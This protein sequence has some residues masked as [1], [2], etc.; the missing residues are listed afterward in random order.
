MRNDQVNMT[1]RQRIQ[2]KYS[3]S[4]AN[5]LLVIILTVV[6]IVLFLAGSDSM[7]LFSAS[8]PYFAVVF[9]W[10][11]DILPMGIIVA[12]IALVLYLVSWIFSKK[13][14]GWMTVALVLFILD[15]LGMLGM[16]LLMEDVSGILD[17]LI[18]AYVLY[19]LIV[20]VSSAKKLKNLPEEEEISAE[21][22]AG[23][24]PVDATPLP[25][26][27][28]RRIGEE[29]KFRVL[30]EAEYGSHK[31]VYRRIKRTNQLVIDNYIYDEVEMLI[32]SAHALSAIIDGHQYVV[33][34]DG[35]A[36]SYFK[37]DG[38]IIA[39]KIRLV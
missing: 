21:I 14:P 30:L 12:V 5:L 22:P 3:T 16:Y 26:T 25:S 15:T 32:E 39:K 11:L 29:E 8:I 35:A 28:L 10:A 20:G 7:L 17:V 24:I 1:E 31:V 37:V 6:N 23:D 33:G 18:H 2:Q 38:E 9:G 34:F 19:Y 27:P 4:R 36:N 13:K